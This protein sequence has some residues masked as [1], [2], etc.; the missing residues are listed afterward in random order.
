MVIR[1]IMLQV[2]ISYTATPPVASKAYR[3]GPIYDNGCSSDIMANARDQ[4]RTE[5]PV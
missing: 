2:R 1:F 5:R 4:W 3:Y